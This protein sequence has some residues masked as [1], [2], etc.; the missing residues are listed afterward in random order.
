MEE[1]ELKIN[2]LKILKNLKHSRKI[3]KDKS[4]KKHLQ[5][6]PCNEAFLD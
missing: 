2:Q 1:K 3:L 6:A 5:K 4:Y